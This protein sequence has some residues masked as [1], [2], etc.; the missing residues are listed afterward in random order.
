[1]RYIFTTL[2]IVMFASNSFSQ[3]CRLVSKTRNKETGIETRGGITNSKDFYSLLIHKTYDP[4]NPKDS[5]NYIVSLSAASKVQLTDSMVN[6]KGKFELTLSNGEKVIWKNAT[7]FNSPAGLSGAIGFQIQ[8]TE[9]QI[10]KIMIHP[11]FKIKA[12]DILETEFAPNKQKQ[13]QKI[14]DC[15][16]NG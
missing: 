13:Q 14:V 2:L 16:I 11:I 3:N 9:K 8:I 10:S 1:M 15:L 6:S 7:C 12:F 5:L 4:S